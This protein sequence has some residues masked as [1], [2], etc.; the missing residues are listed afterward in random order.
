MGSTSKI[1]L[2]DKKFEQVSNFRSM[3][4]YLLRNKEI[5]DK[6]LRILSGKN[7]GEL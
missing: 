7:R 4:E 2:S 5:S 1:H 3:R 6:K